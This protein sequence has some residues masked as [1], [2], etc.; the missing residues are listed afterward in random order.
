MA[1][2]SLDTNVIL[3][4]YHPEDDQYE[5]VMQALETH[6]TGGFC[7]CSPVYAELRAD[8]NWTNHL[9]PFLAALNIEINWNMPMNV[10]DHAGQLLRKYTDLRKGGKLPRRILADFLIAAHAE[11]HKFDVM[12]FDETVYKVVLENVKLI[13]P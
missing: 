7:I 1:V 3:V 12:S 10:W 2:I 8:S 6:Q 9:Q 5:K 13:Q 11:H 4:A